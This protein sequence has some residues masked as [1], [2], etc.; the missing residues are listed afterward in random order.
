MRAALDD[1]ESALRIVQGR[2]TI[3]V[4]V[5]RGPTGGF[6]AGFNG[7]A[8]P[9]TCDQGQHATARLRS[10]ETLTVAWIDGPC[11]GAAFEIALACDYRAGWELRGRVSDSR[12]WRRECYPAGAHQFGCRDS[13]ACSRH[14]NCFLMAGN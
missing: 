11:L 5:M 10:L 6:G 9:A 7:I 13:S 2:P 4:L 14:C 3:E 1:F 8:D 12:R